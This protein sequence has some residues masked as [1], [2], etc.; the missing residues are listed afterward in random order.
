MYGFHSE[1]S[2]KF[3]LLSLSLMI[4][5]DLLKVKKEETTRDVD[6]GISKYHKLRYVKGIY[7]VEIAQHRLYSLIA[8]FFRFYSLTCSGFP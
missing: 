1:A 5:D 2:F 6:Y 3:Q 7:R 8:S 4:R